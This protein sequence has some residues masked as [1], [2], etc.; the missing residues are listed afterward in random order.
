MPGR[1]VEWHGSRG[2]NAVYS[3]TPQTQ[4]CGIKGIIP[5]SVILLGIFPLHGGGQSLGTPF[6]FFFLWI[7]FPTAP[8]PAELGAFVLPA[9]FSAVGDWR[10]GPKPT[11][12]GPNLKTCVRV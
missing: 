8:K 7:P 6:G 10:L 9:A 2:K 1:V 12:I 4:G 11:A 3:T 5:T